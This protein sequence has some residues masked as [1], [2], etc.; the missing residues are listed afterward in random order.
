MKKI[1]CLGLRCPLPI[2]RISQE[3]DKVAVGSQL[4]LLSD[5]PATWPD[6]QAWARMTGNHVQQR[7]TAEFS[8]VRQNQS[9]LNGH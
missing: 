3:I 9:G 8:V 4:I 6:L 2:I 1:D 7:D 5:D